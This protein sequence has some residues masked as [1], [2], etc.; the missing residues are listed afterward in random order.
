MKKLFIIPLAALLPFAAIAQ[1]AVRPAAGTA[2]S[3]VPIEVKVAPHLPKAA[4]ESQLKSWVKN[5]PTEAAQYKEHLMQRMRAANP[6]A[7]DTRTYDVAKQEYGT[8]NRLIVAERAAASPAPA[9][10]GR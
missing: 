10:I 5:Y 2:S 6:N 7:A 1:Q 9:S 3:S 8:V 4:T